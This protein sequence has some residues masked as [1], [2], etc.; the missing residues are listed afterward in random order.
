MFEENLSIFGAST[1][2]NIKKVR[3]LKMMF[4]ASIINPFNTILGLE[5]SVYLLV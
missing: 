2:C 4:D 3:L 5:Y 1:R